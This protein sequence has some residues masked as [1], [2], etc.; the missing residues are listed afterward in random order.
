MTLMYSLKKNLN[1]LLE[2]NLNVLLEINLNILLEKLEIPIEKQSVLPNE[3]A[4]LGK[5][6]YELSL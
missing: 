2:I 1:V 3:T 5:R 4:L 6:K